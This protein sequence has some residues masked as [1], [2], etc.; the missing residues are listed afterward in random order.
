MY[1]RKQR[2]AV[3]QPLYSFPQDHSHLQLSLPHELSE[4]ELDPTEDFLV[5]QVELLRSSGHDV[6]SAN[7]TKTKQDAKRKKGEGELDVLARNEARV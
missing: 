7:T 2:L 3:S 6:Q 4:L 5:P 1:E